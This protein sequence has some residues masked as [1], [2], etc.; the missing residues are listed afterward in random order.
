MGGGAAEGLRRPFSWDN[1]E[2][3]VADPRTGATRC[4]LS[5]LPVVAAHPEP[6]DVGG[7]LGERL[8]HPS[9]PG[10]RRPCQCGILAR[11]RTQ[12]GAGSVAS[13]IHP[14]GV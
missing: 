14:V 3:E 8:G 13:W 5:D 7:E 12:C 9:P 2:A 10:L 4:E 6:D 1:L 11:L